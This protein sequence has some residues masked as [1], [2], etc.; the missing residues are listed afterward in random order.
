MILDEYI[1]ICMYK[2]EGWLDDNIPPKRPELSWN[3][4]GSILGDREVCLGDP[5]PPWGHTPPSA[6]PKS[7]YSSPWA[8]RSLFFPPPPTI[9]IPTAT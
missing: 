3:L 4:A 5:I 9:R 1:H 8:S 6:L 7:N 2:E